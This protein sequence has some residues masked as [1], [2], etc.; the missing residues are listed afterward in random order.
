MLNVKVDTNLKLAF[1]I[2][3]SSKRGKSLSLDKRESL[4]VKREKISV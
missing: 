1:M 2:Y 4:Q 3:L